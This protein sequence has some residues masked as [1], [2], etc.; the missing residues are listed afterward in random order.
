MNNSVLVSKVRLDRL[1]VERGFFPSGE[2]ARR[3]V[4]A[5]EVRVDGRLEDKAGKAVK[6]NCLLS[7]L[8]RYHYVGRGGEK[9]AAA[10]RTFGVS[11]SKKKCLD[12]GASTGGFTDCLLQAG[13]AA[14]V[15]V[16]VGHGQLAQRVREDPR[17]TLLDRTNARYLK[18]SH[19]PYEPELATIDVSFIS[20][21][22]I[23][24]AVVEIIGPGAVLVALIK[25]QFE[26]GRK[27]VGRGGV[28]RDGRVHTSVIWNVC[29][30]CEANGLMVRGLMESPLRGPAGNKEFFVYAEK[31]Q[32][33][34]R[35][36]SALTIV[37]Q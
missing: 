31:S 15:A 14:V 25:P 30:M 19:L 34:T 23:I 6:S 17:V 2:K 21:D 12:I 32:N 24:P 1:L 33:H 9:L 35:S 5:G 8:R 27:D 36:R 29:E 18:R 7:V 13:A 20:L 28:V 3:A 16:D 11:V 37:G 10:L 26:A 4:M 22:K